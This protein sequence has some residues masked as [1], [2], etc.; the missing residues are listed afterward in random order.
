MKKGRRAP[1]DGAPS[2]QR[3]AVTNG[4]RVFVDGDHK[5]P[6]TRRFND[7]VELHER[8]LGP[9]ENLSEL[10]RSL[11]R[12]VALL[13]IELEEMEGKRSKGDDIDLK[14]YRELTGTLGRE[15]RGLGIKRQAQQKG[16][17]S[18]AEYAAMKRGPAS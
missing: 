12:R 6:W 15:A 3:S 11:C 9:R 2:K 4:T 10:Q 7:L 16:P 1:I 18:V 14:L 13:E 17:R 5:S 8:D